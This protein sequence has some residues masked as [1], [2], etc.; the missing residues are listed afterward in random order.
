MARD[1]HLRRPRSRHPTQISLPPLLDE[2]APVSEARVAPAPVP[3]GDQ[4]AH[5]RHVPG[6]DGVGQQELGAAAAPPTPPASLRWPVAAGE[7][8]ARSPG[9][10][11][12]SRAG[13][14][15]P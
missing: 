13:L 3:P 15:P 5:L 6:E 10:W 7:L 9:A 4:V 2:L 1:Q 14:P 8:K 11:F 12:G